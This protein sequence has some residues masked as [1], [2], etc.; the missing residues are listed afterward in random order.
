[1]LT[2]KLLGQG[3]WCGSLPVEDEDGSVDVDF[4][5][6]ETEV[7]FGIHQDGGGV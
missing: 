3:L 5:A 2:C 7:D 6:C 4:R 1:M